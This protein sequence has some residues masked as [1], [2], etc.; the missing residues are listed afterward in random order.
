MSKGMVYY[1]Y[2]SD[3][4]RK[5]HTMQV[6]KS[7]V[8]DAIANNHQALSVYAGVALSVSE[9]EWV[10]SGEFIIKGQAPFNA[11]ARKYL[12]S[13]SVV[14]NNGEVTYTFLAHSLGFVLFG[15]I[16][17]TGDLTLTGFLTL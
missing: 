14:H 10:D 8:L 2:V 12:E 9:V 5:A 16:S 3:L 1:R 13:L 7:R 11:V 17:T 15:E 4:L 6:T